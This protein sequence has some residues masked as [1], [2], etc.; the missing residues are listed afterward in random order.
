MATK[1]LK[2]QDER[3]GDYL[4][5]EK[6]ITSEQLDKAVQCQ[7]LFGGRLGTNLLELGFITE[8]RLRKVLEEKYQVPS[9]S[10]N[11]LK[12]IANE[13]LSLVSRAV[14]E[15]HKLVPVRHQDDALEIAML[16]PFRESSIQALAE[17]T[18]LKIKPLIA[19]ELDLYWALEKHY[20]VKREARFINLDRWLENQRKDGEVSPVK[21]SS[22][23]Y[24][25][26]PFLPNPGDITAMEGAPQSLD[27]F[28]DRVGRTG[29]PEYL[30][31][32]VLRDLDEAKSRDEI[33]TIILDFA[34]VV[35]KIGRAHV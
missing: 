12:E 35:F 2:E 29:H 11:D 27:D 19:L 22:K 10:R 16:D 24:R 17:I 9:V 28:W 34:A 14:A 26:E 13:V 30:L 20:A 8:D 33:A 23:I 4:I 25:S 3:L 6:I 5:R 15:E 31:A 32:R 21:K 7:V 1:P 18:A